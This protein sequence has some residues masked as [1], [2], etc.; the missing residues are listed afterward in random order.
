MINRIN[1][2]ASYIRQ[3][4]SLFLVLCLL[5]VPFG[6]IV[7]ATPATP[8]SAKVSSVSGAPGDTV[9]VAVTVDPGDYS[10]L[11]YMMQL[12]YDPNVLE[13][14]FANPVTDKAASMFF[15]ADANI[16]GTINVYAG[17]FG[18]SFFLSVKQEV[19][20]MHFK[21]KETAGTINSDVKIVSGTYTEDDDLWSNITSVTPGTVSV[22]PISETIKVGIGT[23]SGIPGETVDVPVTVLESSGSAGAYGLQL[24]YDSAALEVENIV[25]TSGDFFMYT[26]N[27]EEGWLKAA[28]ADISGGDNAVKA[29]DSLFIVS[30]KIKENASIGDKTV[31]VSNPNDLQHFTFVDTRIVEMEK[32][33]VPGKVTVN[34]PTNAEAP[35]ISGQPGDRTVDLGGIA[36]LSVTA[37]A[38]GTLSYQWYSN[39]ENSTADGTPLAGE[40]H[41][42]FS[43]PTHMVGT[44]YY[45]V[46]VKNTDNSKTGVKTAS[47]TSSVAKVTV[48]SLTN[49]EAPAISGQPGDRTVD[50]GG[51][52][53][54]S[55]TATAGGTLSYQWYSNTENSTADGTPLAGET[56]ASFSAPTHMVGTAYYYVV[57]KNTDNSKT[58][59]KTAST[60]SSVAKVTVNSLTNA[61]APAISGQP[62]DRTVDLGGIADLSVTATA[63]GTLSYQWYSNT[64]NSTADGTP[65][66]G[67]THASFSAPTNMVGNLYY[68]VVVTNTDNSKTGVKTALTTSSVAKVTVNSLTNAEAPSISGQPEDRT[69]SVGGTADLSVTATANGTLS[70]QWYSNT[71]NSTA[72]GT[73]LAGETHA[74]FSA[75]TNMVGNLYYYVVVTNTDNSKTGVK[76]ASTTSSVAKVTIN[77][78]T[79][80][81]APAISGQPEDRMVSVGGT[82][83]LSVTA[84]AGGTLSYQWYSNTENS[85][86]GGTPLAGET[87]AS[88][89][90]PTNMVGTTYYYVVVKNTDNSKTGV[91]TALTTSSVA[92]VTVNSLTNAETPVISAQLDDRTVS[93]GEAVY[94]NV[95]ATASGTLSYQWY[96]NTENS[97]TGG[98]SLTDETHATFSAP[99]NVEGTTYYYVVV[100]NTDNSKTGERTASATSNVA[101]VAVNSLTN[102]EAPAISA[103]LEDRTVSVGGIAD[104]SVTAI[105]DGTLSY[106]WYSNTE[107]STTGG[108]PLTGETSAA[109]T[110]PT[111][112]VGTTYYYV[113]VTN[114]DNSKSGEKTASVTSSTAKVTVVEPAPSTSAPTETAPS[115]P[116]ATS[117][118]NTGVD[119]LVNGVAERAGIA[120]TSQIGDLKVITVTIDQKKLEDKLA[121]EGRGATVIV[122]VNAEAN[123]V[124]GELNGQMIKNMENQQAK[125]VIQTKNASY[126]LPAIQINIDAVSQLIG[127]EVSLQDIKVQV[128]IA[129]PAAEMAKLVQSES[130]KG[131]FE[132]VAPPIDFTVTATYG[133]E[134]VDVA[135]FNAYVER[136]IAIPEGVDPNRVTTAIVIDPDGTVRHVPTQV[137][138]NGGTYYAKINSLTNSTYSVI[139]HPISYKDVEH[140]WAKEAVNDMGS[141]MIINGI[142]NGDFDPDQDITRAEFAA[143][144]VRGLGLKTDNSMIPFSDVKS[145]DWYSSFISTAHSYNLINGFEDGT[146][147]PLEK[148][149]REQAMVILAKAIKITGL[150]S[151]LQTNNGEELLSSFVDSSHVSAWAAT[152]ITD[153]LQAGIVLGR[154]DHRLE[155][156]APISR[157]EVA[158]T[159][160]RLLQKSGLI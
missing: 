91:K 69:V 148:I 8:V 90:A 19:F 54:L 38:G 152:S 68:Y 60:T 133:G 64:E 137:I 99:T 156:E 136:T 5:L 22:A 110:A 32:T 13:P 82:A 139:W 45:Y 109:F 27:D 56:H 73:P 35:A 81:E 104:L 36:D 42:S 17:Y 145:A 53:D 21:I 46:V 75:P 2:T 77:S 158:V 80:A 10:V 127:S 111:S 11:Q 101:K 85:M 115:V 150:K 9:D 130:E 3:T 41:A 140:H 65:L 58:G 108:T 74:S 14:V 70:Y 121:A 160:K 51:I 113:V 79:N 30:F 92:K 157:A 49:A 112:A 117:A 66:A 43:A 129:T 61:E 12:S 76:T 106:Q 98:T 105:A 57:V 116:T 125:L 147:R 84:T 59:V 97:T 87:H 55:V 37:T 143:I 16:S 151:N 94:L 114:T 144:I 135:K 78:L 95:T 24:D 118:P 126:T 15:N 50:L 96:S 29:G 131:A 89:S 123:I 103:Q 6:S 159:V 155:P 154:S 83:D 88:F 71:E 146:F 120:V 119:V 1:G 44:A 100:T 23:A 40:T 122:P 134:T 25:G 26:Q 141:R 4:F 153:I 20:V 67:E 86:T 72:D 107:N 124:I 48:N 102:A 28:W 138:L 39:T 62:G 52:A 18:G 149:T 63:G 142:G 93:V 128:K 132:L 47:T 34:E 33:F 7:Q 31:T